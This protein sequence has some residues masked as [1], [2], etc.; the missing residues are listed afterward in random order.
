MLCI[1]APEY[2]SRDEESRHRSA[3]GEAIGESE[4]DESE[5]GTESEADPS[6]GELLPTTAV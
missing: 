4:A 3:D 2:A 6:D 1:I 5:G